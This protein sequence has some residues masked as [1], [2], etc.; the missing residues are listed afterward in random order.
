[1]IGGILSGIH[2]D[3]ITSLNQLHG[4][5]RG[6]VRVSMT[7]KKAAKKLDQKVSENN[8][9]LYSWPNFCISEQ[10]F[11]A[12]VLLNRNVSMCRVHLHTKCGTVKVSMRSRVEKNFTSRYCYCCGLS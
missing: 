8:V 6:V 9:F 3:D 1:M 10:M 11:S 12:L 2:P 4:D 5:K 7:S